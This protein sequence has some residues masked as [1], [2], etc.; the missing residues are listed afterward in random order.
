MAG[1]SRFRLT[2]HQNVGDITPSLQ[3]YYKTFS[4][5]TG[6]SAP[7]PRIGTLVLVGL[8]LGR[9]PSHRGD[10]FLASAHEPEPDSRLLNAGR[11]AGGKQVSPA[12]IPEQP[13]S[14]VLTSSILFRHF[15]ARFAFA[16]L[17]GS[18]LTRCFRAFSLTLTTPA[19]DRRRSR[20]FAAW[21]CTP[22]ARGLPSFRARLSLAHGDHST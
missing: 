21:A 19:L 9:L 10:R 7:V 15:I 17:S 20:W 2:K 18:H 8:P 11:H 14:P 12:L 22:T 1:S 16:R 5:T 6:D 13:P 4:A 3:S